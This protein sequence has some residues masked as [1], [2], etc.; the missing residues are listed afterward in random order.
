[1]LIANIARP[2]GRRRAQPT[3]NIE[4][5]NQTAHNSYSRSSGAGAV[6][7][8]RLAQKVTLLDPMCR[9]ER[10]AENF[11][12][13]AASLKDLIPEPPKEDPP[14]FACRKFKYVPGLIC[15]FPAMS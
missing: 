3:A 13:Q 2:Y 4:H 9:K 14:K 1:M 11:F 5:E 7:M 15:T 12:S 6:L 8:I 10:M